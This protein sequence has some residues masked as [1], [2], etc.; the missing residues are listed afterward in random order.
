M[1]TFEQQRITV[2]SQSPYDVVIDRGTDF[3]AQEILKVAG[4]TAT[5]LIIHQP[6]LSARAK[7]LAGRLTEAGYAAHTHEIQDAESAKTAHSAAECWDVCADIGLTRAD[8]II[9][10][11]G[12]AATDLAGFIAATWMR[13]IKV[14]HYPTTLLAMVDAAVGGKTGINTPAG[15]NLVGAFHEPSAVIVD[16]EVLET[17]PREEMVAGSAEIIK[18]GFIAD[19]KILDIYEADPEASLDPHGS[20]PELIARAIQVKADVVAVDLKESSLREILNYGHTYGHA[21]EHYEDYRWRH[22]Q[23]V[24]VGMIFEAELAKAA[25]L[26]GEADVRRH[27]DILS[28]VGLATSYNGAKLDEL[29]AAMGRDK[30]NKGGKIRFVVLEEIGKPT[31]LEGPSE[32][33]LRAAY[34]AS[35]EA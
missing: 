9:G 23:A 22:G 11:G 5:Y 13:G 10:L 34:A 24:A 7:P 33:L 12:G 3:A 35:V 8:T 1:N 26:L 15:K 28:S 21:V 25:G 31:R 2:A 32:D 29:L 17:L 18:A 14:V 27:R 16:L 30:K 4:A 19:T 6:A 20:L